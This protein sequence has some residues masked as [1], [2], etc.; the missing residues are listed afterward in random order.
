MGH[1]DWGDS[2]GQFEDFG[3]ELPIFVDLD[4]AAGDGEL[5]SS[6]SAGAGVHVENAFVAADFRFVAVTVEDCGESGCCGI[7]IDLVD[8][9]EHVEIAAAEGCYFGLWEFGAGA[10]SI[11]ITPDGGHWGNFRELAEDFGVAYVAEV[12]D[13]VGACE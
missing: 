10:V 5:E 13:V 6:W 9:V 7:E 12:Q 3:L 11:D 1:P 2:D 8:V 4:T